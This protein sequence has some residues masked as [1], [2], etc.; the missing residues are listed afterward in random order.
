MMYALLLSAA[1]TLIGLGTSPLVDSQHNHE[2]TPVTNQGEGET[3]LH[4]RNWSA[5][6]A[7]DGRTLNLI[8]LRVDM[9]DSG[10][11]IVMDTIIAADCANA[12]LG[13]KEAYFFQSPFGNGIRMPIDY[14]EMD[15]AAEPLGN[16]DAAILDAACN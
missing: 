11:E 15:L 1:A 2:W 8:L 12:E 4:D 13:L 16:D 5:T 3:A 9:V 6:M 7:Q 10:D 14:V